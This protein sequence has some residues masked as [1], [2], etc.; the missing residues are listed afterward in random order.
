MV[1]VRVELQ[2]WHDLIKV[3]TI[4]PKRLKVVQTF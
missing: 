4:C 1:D 2:L 3:A